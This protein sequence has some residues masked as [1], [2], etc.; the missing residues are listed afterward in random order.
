MAIS[1]S[2]LSQERGYDQHVSFAEIV[3]LS[4]ITRKN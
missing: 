4:V 2:M 3:N 1:E